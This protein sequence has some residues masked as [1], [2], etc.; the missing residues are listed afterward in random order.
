MN[1]GPSR[2]LDYV[3]IFERVPKQGTCY[4]KKSLFNPINSSETEDNEHL[5]NSGVDKL[6]SKE[7]II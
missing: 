5:Y 6:K 4:E 2:L 3:D 1:K 7:L